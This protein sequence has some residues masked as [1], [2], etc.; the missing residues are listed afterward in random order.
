LDL[1]VPGALRSTVTS[2]GAPASSY[3]VPVGY[4]LSAT[5]FV[6]DLQPVIRLA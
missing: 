2:E 4:A 1:H 5:E 3:L 6:L